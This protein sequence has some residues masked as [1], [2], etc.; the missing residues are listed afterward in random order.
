MIEAVSTPTL[1]IALE[2]IAP[3]MPVLRSVKLASSI[4]TALGTPVLTSNRI[5][6]PCP[7]S[8]L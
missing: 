6:I 8:T 3:A 1:A 7:G 4:S 5:I 2:A